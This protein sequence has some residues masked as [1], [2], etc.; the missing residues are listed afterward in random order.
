MGAIGTNI[1][2]A[3]KVGP[4]ALTLITGGRSFSETLIAIGRV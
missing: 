3:E 1:P 4:L 2:A